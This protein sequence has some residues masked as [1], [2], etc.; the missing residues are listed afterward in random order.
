[1][2][3]R[4]DLIGLKADYS[5]TKEYFEKLKPYVEN[6]RAQFK[7]KKEQRIK[8]NLLYINKRRGKKDFVT[9]DLVILQSLHL[10]AGRGMRAIGAPGIILDICKSGKSALVENILTNRVAKY[11]FSYLRRISTPIFAKLPDRWKDQIQ[12]IH[13]AAPR[14]STSPEPHFDEL[15][16][17]PGPETYSQQ[18]DEQHPEIEESEEQTDPDSLPQS[19][20]DH[21]GRVATTEEET[22]GI[23]EPRPLRDVRK[24]RT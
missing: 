14:D 6:I 15:L 16:E 9:G 23:P 24:A 1:M 10:A 7:K 17:E 5:N 2:L 19:N 12:K 20:T 4:G 11:N 21:Q 18:S 8:S 13:G 22:G 3:P